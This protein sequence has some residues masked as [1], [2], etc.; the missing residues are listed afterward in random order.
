M[1]REPAAAMAVVVP[2]RDEEALLAA[3]LFALADAVEVAARAGIRTEVRV[4]LDRC[5]DSS[6]D[7]ARAFPFPVLFS[8]EGRVGAARAL[9]VADA[10]DSLRGVPRS[11]VWITNTD[12]DSRVPR[13]WLTH[14]REISRRADVCLGTVRPEFADLTPQQRSIWLRTHIRGRPA[15]NVHGA[16]LGLSAAHYV[17]VGGFAPLGEHEDVDLVARCRN[18]GAL[19]AVS[20][21]AEVITSG[22][23]TGRTPGGYSG[24]LRRQRAD[25]EELG[26]RGSSV[27]P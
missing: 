22:R 3:S 23:T 26:S 7:V 10:L 17:A 4:V 27:D 12:A 25:L 19:V 2:V 18:A 8:G 13:N 6:E 21:E 1:S 16:N 14:F 5:S 24:F 11:R 20:D 15:G 9:G